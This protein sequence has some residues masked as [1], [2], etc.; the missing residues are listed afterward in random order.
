MAG[1]VQESADYHSG[2]VHLHSRDRVVSVDR[3]GVIYHPRKLH[4]LAN[5][6]FM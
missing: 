3:R 6:Y 2:S 5:T 1:V 4:E